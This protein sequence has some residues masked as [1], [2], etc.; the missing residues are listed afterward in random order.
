MKREKIICE[1]CGCKDK[2]T[3]ERHHITEQT[4]INTNNDDFNLAIICSNCHT[5]HHLGRLKIIGLVASTQLPYKR[6]LIYQL[7]GI[8]NVEG[9]DEFCYKPKQKQ[10]KL[11]GKNG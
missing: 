7:D 11:K 1:V 9:L 5:K 2:E 10:M 6:T 3:L 8:K 4:E